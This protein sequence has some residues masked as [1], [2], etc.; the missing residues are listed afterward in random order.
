MRRTIA[1]SPLT[2]LNRYIDP[3]TGR[4]SDAATNYL[5][6]HTDNPNLHILVGKRVKRVIFE[7]VTFF[8]SGVHLTR[9]SIGTKLQL[10]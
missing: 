6:P 7:C 9:S 3:K 5:Y 2:S 4:R 1:P 8:F 10:E